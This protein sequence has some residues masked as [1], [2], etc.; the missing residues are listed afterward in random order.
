MSTAISDFLLNTADNPAYQQGQFQKNNIDWMGSQLRNAYNIY[1]SVNPLQQVAAFDPTRQLGIEN[2]LSA[3]N[4]V[5]QDLAGQGAGTL[6]GIQGGMG[7]SQQA[8]RG[9]AGGLMGPTFDTKT[10]QNYSNFMNPALLGAQQSLANQANMA[11][12]Q[13]AAGIGGGA[14][15]FMSSGRNAALGQAQENAATQLG[16]QQQQLA[17]QAANQA[18]QAGQSSGQLGYQGQLSAAGTLGQNALSAANM[19]GALQQA[20]LL[21]GT[22]QEGYGQALQQQQQNQLNAQ[23]QNQLMAQQNPYKNISLYGGAAGAM[24]PTSQ[25]MNFSLPNDFVS[26]LNMAGGAAGNATGSSILNG[27]FGK[28]IDYVTKQLFG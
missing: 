15:G 19:T 11:W 10:A 5:G 24:S 8:L 16:A 9:I 1:G 14:G 2:Q 25:A 6:Q 22:L 13:G 17:Y 23:Y 3:A 27:L 20:Q 26:L 7:T 4:G 28:G 21:P 12:N 18:A